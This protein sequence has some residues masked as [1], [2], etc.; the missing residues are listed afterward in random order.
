MNQS[1]PVQYSQRDFC[2]SKQPFRIDYKAAAIKSDLDDDQMEQ[3]F[4]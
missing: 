4:N 2:P 1:C 3:S